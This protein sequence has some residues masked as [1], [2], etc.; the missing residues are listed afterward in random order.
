[1]GRINQ[2]DNPKKSGILSDNQK[3]L[4]PFF[5]LLLPTGKFH[6]FYFY[7]KIKKTLGCMQNI[8]LE[9]IIWDLYQCCAVI[10]ILKELLVPVFEVSQNQKSVGSGSVKKIRIKEF[11]IPGIS[12][13]YSFHERT[14]GFLAG[15]LIFCNSLRT[16]IIHQNWVFQ[17][18][19]SW[20]WIPKNTIIIVDVLIVINGFE[21][22]T[23]C[24]RNHA[25]CL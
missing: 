15:Y 20:L 7:S 9:I 21:D 10:W 6:Y 14:S 11:L 16:M 13:L 25:S 12:D 24:Y 1:M 8:F 18:L 22:V 17:F 5:F 2:E 23:K 3:N 19:E 4:G